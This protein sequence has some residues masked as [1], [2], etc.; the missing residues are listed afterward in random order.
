MSINPIRAYQQTLSSALAYYKSGIE[1]LVHN[2][3]VVFNTVREKGNYRSFDGP[4]IRHHLQ[5]NKGGV[6]WATGYDF[7]E[8]P[9]VELFNDAVFFPSAV[10]SPISFSGTQLRANTGDRMIPLMR[11]YIESATADLVD[12]LEVAINGNGT[13]F[14]GRD[15]VGLGAALPLVTNTGTYGGISRTVP[16]WQ[17]TTFDAA[18]DFPTIGTTINST[19]IQPML[20]RISGLRSRGNRY[21]D[22]LI[23]SQEPFD[24]LEASMVAHQRIVN[25]TR[26]GRVGFS[27]LEFICG[28][29]RLEAVLASGLN[30]S[31]PSN[32]VYGLESRS[33]YVYYRDEL[34][35]DQLFEGQGQMPINQDAIAQYL[36]WEGQ[37]VLGNPLFSWR[38]HDSQA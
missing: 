20:R 32:T 22:L 16:E 29:K 7:L 34:N 26:L 19:T 1:D 8:N 31:M 27:S 6:Q 4:E 21:A 33:L 24:A 18:T 5:F 13:S 30:S 28:G 12:G 15:M 37:F 10:Y 2:S 25:E 9:P 17:T 3:N 23:M 11:N 35:F 14:N 38:L 36:G